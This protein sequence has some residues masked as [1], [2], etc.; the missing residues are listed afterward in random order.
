[1]NIKKQK[2]ILPTHICLKASNG[3]NRAALIAGYK[4]ETTERTSEITNPAAN[5]EGVITVMLAASKLAPR[6]AP[7]AL[8]RNGLP[9]R[10]ISTEKP[11]PSRSP[12]IPPITPIIRH[13]ARNIF[14]MS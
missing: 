5:I 13:S 1:M 4:P 2:K 6:S 7:S 10:S 11:I 8:I 14:I 9:T 12:K 3:F